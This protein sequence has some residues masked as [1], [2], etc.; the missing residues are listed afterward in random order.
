MALSPQAF[1]PSPLHWYLAWNGVTPIWKVKTCHVQL[2]LLLTDSQSVFTLL[3]IASAFLQLKFFWN[4]WDLS[5]SISSRVTRSFQWIPSNTGLPG[6]D[7]TDS[8]A[9]IGATLPFIH[10]SCPL[11]P[12]I[13]KIKHS[14]LFLE[15]K[16]VPQLPLLPD[17]FSFLGGTSPFPFRPLSTVPTSL[18]RSQPSLALLPVQ[19]KTACGHLLQDLTHLLLDCSA[20]ELAS[21][22]RY[23]WQ[24]FFHFSTLVQTLRSGLTVRFPWSSSTP[25]SVGRGR[26]APLLPPPPGNKLMNI[27]M[28]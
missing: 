19:D 7:L 5:D 27:G 17:S 10:V 24:Y 1:Q 22:A 12:V 20:I 23:L 14:L 4:I 8:L 11:T 25:S 21:P 3:S 6:N 18:L 28:Q 9:K 15:T 2:A 26:V 13:A 16:S